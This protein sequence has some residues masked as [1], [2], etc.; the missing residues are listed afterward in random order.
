[1]NLDCEVFV[2]YLL[3]VCLQFVLGVGDFA[4]SRIESHV[5]VVVLRPHVVGAVLQ[6]RL[7]T[8]K[9]WNAFRELLLMVLCINYKR[10]ISSTFT[11]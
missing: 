2:L 8:A 6:R 5:D 11:G 1:M 4:D 10:S 9:I 7:D 3:S